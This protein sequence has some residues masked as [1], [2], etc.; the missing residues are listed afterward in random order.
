MGTCA[1]LSEITD[2]SLVQALV[3]ADNECTANGAVI[4]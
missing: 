3:D 1:D 4:T 2:P